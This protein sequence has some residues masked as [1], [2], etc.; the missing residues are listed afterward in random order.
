MKKL[1]NKVKNVAVVLT[2]LS[3]ASACADYLDVP[4][5]GLLSES[6]FYQ[7]DNDALVALSG[8][9]DR[10]SNTYNHIWASMYLIREI[11]SDDT[12]AGGADDRDQA[13]HQ[14]LDDFKHDASNDQ[15]LACWKNLWT[16][17]YRANKLINKTVADTDL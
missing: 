13:G 14:L 1:I 4:V 2:G 11:R 12:N 7:T 6:E 8:V 9:Y 10:L 17:V 5:N 16:V 3:I 15:V